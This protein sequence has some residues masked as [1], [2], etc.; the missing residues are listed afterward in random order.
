MVM[1]TNAPEKFL[2]PLEAG[3]VVA[4][5]GKQMVNAIVKNFREIA[6]NP[7]IAAHHEGLRG[8]A[9]K[10]FETCAKAVDSPGTLA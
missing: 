9:K 7:Q 6:H 10:L 5:P 2:L 1:V 4:K 8:A 3:L